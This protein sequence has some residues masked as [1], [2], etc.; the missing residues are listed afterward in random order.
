MHQTHSPRAGLP[1][2]R[3]FEDGIQLFQ[4]NGLCLDIEEV[5]EH[6]LKQVPEYEEHIEPVADL[7]RVR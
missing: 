6:K 5:N 4:G 7:Q 1:W 3:R 2:V